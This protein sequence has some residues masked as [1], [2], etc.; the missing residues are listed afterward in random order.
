MNTQVLHIKMNSGNITRAIINLKALQHNQ[1]VLQ[2]KAPNS[3]NM[4]VVKAN[5]YGHGMVEIAR[6]LTGIH[7][8]GVAR[9]NEALLLRNAGITRPIVLLE[10]F[11]HADDIKT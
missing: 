1:Q 7:A 3:Q 8:L 4:A 10:G 5:A 9:L 2:K 11:F 6:T